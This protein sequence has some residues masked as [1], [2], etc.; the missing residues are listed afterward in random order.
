M[1]NE[2]PRP[3]LPNDEDSWESLAENLFGIEFGAMPNAGEIIP[4]EELSVEVAKVEELPAE[5]AKV[6][7]EPP[8]P[9]AP[10]DV[11]ETPDA[12]QAVEELTL[13]V[14]DVAVS[15]VAESDVAE[16]DVAEAGEIGDEKSFDDDK[17]S[18]AKDEKPSA[19]SGGGSNADDAY[20]DVLKDWDWGEKSSNTAHDRKRATSKSSSSHKAAPVKRVDKKPARVTEDFATPAE[21]RDEYVDASDF[22]AGLLDGENIS[23]DD[24][25]VSTLK[26]EPASESIR[27]KAEDLEQGE[28]VSEESADETDPKKRKRRRRRRRRPR[29]AESTQTAEQTAEQ[30]D[31]PAAEPESADDPN[32]EQVVV[33]TQG[34]ADA[35]EEEPTKP[36]RST[37]RRPS[38]RRK[39]AAPAAEEKSAEEKSAEEKSTEEKSTEEKSTED[40]ASAPASWESDFSHDD[41]DEHVEH[42]EHVEHD[43]H[44]EHD[45]AMSTSDKASLYHDVPTWEEA[46]SYLLDP[47]LAK[48]HA[49][50]S[51]SGSPGK[52]KSDSTK[53]ASRRGRR[54]R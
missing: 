31:A 36:K 51:E 5:V 44:D 10:A 13:D 11:S 17:K 32:D 27:V 15:D 35:T 52:T 21:F 45:E 20:W 8:A 18:I 48:A 2:S 22:G 14:S 34:P 50:A 26:T 54:R 46:I 53:P 30:T 23:R 49:T 33:V 38:R 3:N 19:R 25:P 28:A 39:P 9:Q 16:S 7:E 4:P 47:S 1:K 6:S 40:D 43:E 29:T 24:E 42:V 41:H 12:P 37:R